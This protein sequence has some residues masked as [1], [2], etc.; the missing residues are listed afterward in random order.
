MHAL[1][2]VTTQN[3]TEEIFKILVALFSDSCIGQHPIRQIERS[4]EELHKRKTYK[5][6]GTGTRNNAGTKDRLIIARSLSLL[7]MGGAYLTDYPIDADQ[8]MLNLKFLF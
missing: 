3:S 6:E 2:G 8:E 1:A 5:Y 7:G 4:A